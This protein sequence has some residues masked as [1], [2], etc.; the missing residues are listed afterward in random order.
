M[1]CQSLERKITADTSKTTANAVNI[2]KEISNAPVRTLLMKKV[3]H[4]LTC[5]STDKTCVRSVEDDKPAVIQSI[6]G[7]A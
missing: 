7:E 1:S 4:I 2:P 3:Y 6:R 5:K